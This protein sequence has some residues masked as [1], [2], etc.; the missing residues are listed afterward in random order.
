M[1]IA[2]GTVVTTAETAATTSDIGKDYYEADDGS[3]KG[4]WRVP[5]EKELGLI[6]SYLPVTDL[7]AF[8]FSRTKYTDSRYYYI[9]IATE[10]DAEGNYVN[11]P[12]IT[13][14][15][16]EC[17]DDKSG[18]VIL[19]RDVDPSTVPAQTSYDGSYSSGGTAFGVKL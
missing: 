8:T 2:K 1:K 12:F 13:T 17:P 11:V 18:Q 3:D 16:D 5:N 7:S 19:V 15:Q 10:V 6:L 14:N 4:Q 9:Q